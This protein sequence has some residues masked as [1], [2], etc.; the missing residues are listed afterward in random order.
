MNKRHIC[1][2][3][4]LLSVLLSMPVY[5]ARQKKTK[6]QNRHYVDIHVAAGYTS[7]LHNTPDARIVGGGGFL[8]GAGYEYNRKNWFLNVGMEFQFHNSTSFMPDMN[9]SVPYYYTPLTDY[10]ITY[11]YDATHI[12]ST[13]NTGMLTM[14]LSFGYRFSRYYAR[15]GVALG[16]GVFGTDHAKADVHINVTDPEFAEPM[17]NV[18][19]M[20]G[21]N[22]YSTDS[23]WQVG[24]N[25]APMAEIGLYLD[26]W[27]VRDNPK[28][29]HIPPSFRLGLFAEYGAMNIDR[30]GY[31]AS[32]VNPLIAGVHFT[33]LISPQK[34]PKAR[35]KKPNNQNPKPKTEP[36]P[37]PPVPVDTIVIHEDTIEYGD[38]IIIKE[39][40]VVLENLMFVFGT[41]EIIPESTKTLDRLLS[42]MQNRSEL[43][44]HVTGHTDNIGTEAY[45]KRL[46]LDRAE[47]VC[48]YLIKHGIDKQR[49][50]FSGEGA[51]KPIDTNDTEEGRQRNR[52]VEITI[53]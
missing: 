49:M 17:E 1:I 48:L 5:G 15:A 19:H 40:P 53:K 3:F 6:I 26:E 36:A 52:R 2:V 13:Y 10:I 28:R 20:T 35:T 23:K 24:F 50:T 14:P 30:N 31:I 25:I 12:R 4:I 11:G 22:A 47:A 43:K 9:T 32:S 44:I 8:L 51:D 33:A 16:I 37:T 18:G 34:A 21:T 42:I 39:Q 41:A 29:K 38:I 46:S 7:L 27:L 45:N